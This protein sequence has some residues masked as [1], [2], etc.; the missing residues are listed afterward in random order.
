ML[1]CLTRRLGPTSL[2]TLTCVCN[3]LW[4]ITASIAVRAKVLEQGCME[5]AV[6]IPT[7][8]V[9]ATRHSN[10][11][12]LQAV[13]PLL[14]WLKSRHKL[15]RDAQS[16]LGQAKSPRDLLQAMLEALVQ[17]WRCLSFI[18]FWQISHCTYY[19]I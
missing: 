4:N 14:P 1:L 19:S 9:S 13:A 17:D 7:T 6:C 15:S 12:Q 10:Q 3:V 8:T 16:L 5:D 11:G 2:P 18:S